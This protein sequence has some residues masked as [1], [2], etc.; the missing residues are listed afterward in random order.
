[1]TEIED[2]SHW[3]PSLI[4]INE[5]MNK[6]FG[7]ED[8]LYHILQ[9]AN[10]ETA[11]FNETFLLIVELMK[12]CTDPDIQKELDKIKPQDYPEDD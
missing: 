7:I 5:R 2:K 4:A 6:H 12:K 10:C 9:D 3:N 11:Y 8:Q 1:M